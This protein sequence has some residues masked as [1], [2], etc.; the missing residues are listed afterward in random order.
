M[1]FRR[2]MK[3]STLNGTDRVTLNGTDLNVSRACLGTMTFGSPASENDSRDILDYAIDHGINFVDTANIYSHGAAE[4]ILGRAF[5]SR[6]HRLVL[7]S[8]VFGS[9]GGG[10]LDCG[11]SRDAMTKA[12]EDSLRRLQ[13][14]YLDLYYL[15]QP[16]YGVPLEETL[17]T[18]ERMIYQGKVR[19]AACSNFGSWQMCRMHWIADKQS[20]KSIGIAQQMYNLLARGVEQE[21]L[22]MAAQF[23]ISTLA[24]NPLAGGL[25]TGKHGNSTPA[26]GS[27]FVNNQVYRNRYWHPSC[28]EAVGRLQEVAAKCGRSLTSLSLNW[29]LHH[30][31]VTGIVLGASRQD[32]LATNLHALEEGALDSETV[33][34][35]DLVS[36]SLNACTPRYNR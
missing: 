26:E 6:R 31:G 35:C 33:Q 29:L 23:G 30:S 3:N 36:N 14:D 1:A 25:L 21:F 18:L 5:N 8:K 16:D 10:P 7:A 34:A 17:A 19:F 22:P 27:R 13:T 4:E 28:L 12:L 11:L 20:Y 24:Y 9:M 15:H 2:K 32:Q